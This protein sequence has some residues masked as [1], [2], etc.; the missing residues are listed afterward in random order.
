MGLSCTQR[1]RRYRNRV[2]AAHACRPPSFRPLCTWL[3][4]ALFAACAAGE[5]AA[6]GRLPS[7]RIRSRDRTRTRTR[8]VDGIRFVP[9]PDELLSVFPAARLFGV[10]VTRVAISSNG[11]IDF[12]TTA[13]GLSV[14]V[15]SLR[16][17]QP[18]RSGLVA[19]MWTFYRSEDGITAGVRHNVFHGMDWRPGRGC[20]VVSWE[21]E[22]PSVTINPEVWRRSVPPCIR[23]SRC[24]AL[25]ALRAADPSARP[26]PARR[27]KVQLNV[28]PTGEIDFMFET[29][30]LA[31]DQQAASG[32]EF[33]GGLMGLPVSPHA[34]AN[35]SS[36]AYRFAPCTSLISPAGRSLI[37]HLAY[38]P[39]F[40]PS[41][42][43]T[44]LA[45]NSSQFTTRSLSSP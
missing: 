31:P 17:L 10:D 37:S 25:C 16:S 27:I 28:W 9:L 1:R 41:A 36:V 24:F 39:Q 44:R 6:R 20:W 7:A 12:N 2:H 22:V 35:S 19:P 21:T 32:A 13:D 14:P 4:L 34:L 40:S 26:H 8:A 5:Q 3:E 15:T 23:P 30:Q 29:T 45:S 11:F 33:L 38:C 18:N 43:S 42:P